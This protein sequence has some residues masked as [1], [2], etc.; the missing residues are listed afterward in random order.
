[1]TLVNAPEVS[2]CEMCGATREGVIPALDAF[3]SL[4]SS[5]GASSSTRAAQSST[6]D[7][8][9]PA[10][11]AKGGKQKGK[12]GTKITIRLGAT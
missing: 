11:S 5:S 7:G 1:C 3:P 12:G 4:P 8:Q 6:A 2:A 9:S 10:S